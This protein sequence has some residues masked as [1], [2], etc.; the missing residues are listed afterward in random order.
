MWKANRDG[1]DVQFIDELSLALAHYVTGYVTKAERSNMQDVWQEISSNNWLWSFGIR[2]L[3][4]RE[5][6]LYEARTCCLVIICVKSQTQ[7]TIPHL[8]KRRLKD[9][10]KLQEL[11]KSDPSSTKIIEDS[12]ILKGQ[13]TWTRFAFTILSSTM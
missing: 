12:A 5:C 8:R 4:S 6:R 1:M 10:N 7:S 2:S 13:M 11:G 9:H 3:R